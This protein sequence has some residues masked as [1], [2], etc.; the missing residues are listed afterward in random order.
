MPPEQQPSPAGL[1]QRWSRYR[2]RSQRILNTL[3][4]K[5]QKVGHIFSRRSGEGDNEGQ[6]GQ[7]L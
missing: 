5:V 6:T 7:T 1:K 2:N 3:Y 4:A